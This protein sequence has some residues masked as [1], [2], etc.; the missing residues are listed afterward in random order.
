MKLGQHD[1]PAQQLLVMAVINRTPDS[2][3]DQGRHYGLPAA[4]A[5]VAAAIANGADIVDIGG[6]KAAP[7]PAVPLAE[8]IER[9]VPVVTEVRRRYPAVVISVDTWRSEVA[10]ACAEA[11]ADLINDAWGGYDPDLAEV[12]ARYGCGLVC[13][14]AGTLVPRTVARGLK[15]VD[16]VSEVKLRLLELASRAVA[17]GVNPDSILID[18]GHDFAKNTVH[19]LEVTRRIGE[20]VQ[21]G[22]PVLV[23]VSNKDFIGESLDLP[24]GERLE[25]TLA[26]L[27]L[28][29]WMGVRVFRV[30]NV[31]EARRTLDMVSV[32]MGKKRP[33]VAQRAVD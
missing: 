8:E 5:A 24:V 21:A 13:T 11:G 1:F 25:G 7:G 15:Y 31:K 26:V 14:H 29:A 4:L 2:F 19:S 30:H 33:L 9:V 20:I 28:C 12:A 10:Q 6:V 18:P 17:L 16:V 22:W 32:V 27:A 23:A 3:Y